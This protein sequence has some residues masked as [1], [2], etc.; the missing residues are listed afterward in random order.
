M[1][2]NLGVD[3]EVEQKGTHDEAKEIC[4][5]KVSV[6]LIM[7]TIAPLLH[8]ILPAAG[9]ALLA[10]SLKKLVHQRYENFPFV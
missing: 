6:P 8:L 1:G 3:V 7:V 5:P 9:F 4:L 10:I 2:S